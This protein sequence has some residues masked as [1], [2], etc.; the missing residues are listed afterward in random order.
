MQTNVHSLEAQV[1]GN[2]PFLNRLPEVM[3]GALRIIHFLEGGLQL[4]KACCFSSE[5]QA[6][7]ATER[8]IEGHQSHLPVLAAQRDIPLSQEVVA[9]CVRLPTPGGKLGKRLVDSQVEIWVNEVKGLAETVDTR[10]RHPAGPF[11][12]C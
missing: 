7:T 6:N 4:S 5:L 11:V 3:A 2:W 12:S 10:N 1:C 8:T 9:L